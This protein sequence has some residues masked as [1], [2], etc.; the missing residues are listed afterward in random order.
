M[1]NINSNFDKK[2]RLD[3]YN[4]EIFSSE[5]EKR[6]DL[7]GALKALSIGIEYRGENAYLLFRRGIIFFKMKKYK[8]AINDFSKYI[9]SMKRS[10]YSFDAL[11]LKECCDLILNNYIPGPQTFSYI[12]GKGKTYSILNTKWGECYIAFLNSLERSLEGDFEKSLEHLIEIKNID[13]NF[14]KNYLKDETLC[15]LDLLDHLPKEMKPIL[16]LCW[17]VIY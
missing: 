4:L 16:N 3:E 11:F 8:E 13:Q 17:E 14:L 10:A 5:K 12:F 9:K 15:L 6:G 1:D 2:K 7:K